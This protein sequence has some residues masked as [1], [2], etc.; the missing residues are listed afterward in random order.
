MPK[1]FAEVK[2][3]TRCPSRA[4]RGP[5]TAASSAS[6]CGSTAGRGRRPSSPS[7]TTSTPGASG[8]E[9]DAKPGNHLIEV[10]ATDDTGYTQTDKRVP[11]A[12]DGSTGWHNVN[13]T[14]S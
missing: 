11:I 5:S 9:W 10:R 8:L 6:R 13:V 14:A 12:P 4:W 1:S 7:R 3:G 2:A